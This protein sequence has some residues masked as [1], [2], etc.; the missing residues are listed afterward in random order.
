MFKKRVDDNQKKLVAEL[1]KA[2]LEV[3]LLYRQ[4]DGCPDL[5]VSEPYGVNSKAW[6]VEVKSYGGRRTEAENK[7]FA[8]WRGVPVITAQTAA[9]VLM[10]IGWSDTPC[11]KESS[12]CQ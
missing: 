11:Q 3:L 6:L 5:L 8:A 1:R 2:G 9:T 7:F 12:D 10:L 4:G